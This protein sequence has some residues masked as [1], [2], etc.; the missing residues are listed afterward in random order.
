M[1]VLKKQKTDNMD[2]VEIEIK[3]DRD[4][5]LETVFEAFEGFLRSVGY[6]IDGRIGIEEKAE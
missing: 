3:I 1:I 4:A 5:N 6:V 2:Q